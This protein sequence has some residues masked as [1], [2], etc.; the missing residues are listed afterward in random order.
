M[1]LTPP[2]AGGAPNGPDG[3][4]GK[5]PTAAGSV[6]GE[7]EVPAIIGLDMRLDVDI[8]IDDVA[9][10]LEGWP[11]GPDCGKPLPRRVDW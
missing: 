8:D 10:E 9:V 1:L 5:L 7:L 3:G 2:N 4:A 6:K 11:Y